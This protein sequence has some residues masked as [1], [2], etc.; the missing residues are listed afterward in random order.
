MN[1]ACD[2]SIIFHMFSGFRSCF[3]LWFIQATPDPL[4]KAWPW[5]MFHWSLRSKLQRMGE[6]AHFS[7]PSAGISVHLSCPALKPN[8]YMIIKGTVRISELVVTC[9][10]YVIW[11]PCFSFEG[12]TWAYTIWHMTLTLLVSKITLSGALVK[13]PVLAGQLLT[14]NKFS[15]PSIHTLL[16]WF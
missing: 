3:L 5:V 6:F 2:I 16:I 1:K 7:W 10:H 11:F 8:W 12:A 13:F 15:G 4:G 14:S 9:C